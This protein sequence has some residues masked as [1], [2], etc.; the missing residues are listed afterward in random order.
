MNELI[1]IIIFIGFVFGNSN[2]LQRSIVT[3]TRNKVKKI[4]TEKKFCKFYNLFGRCCRGDS[5]TYVHDAKRV[6]VCQR[7]Y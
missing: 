4:T 6:A 2:L 7:Y 3:I 1:N 5:C